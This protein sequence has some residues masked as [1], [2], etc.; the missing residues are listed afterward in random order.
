MEAARAIRLVAAFVVGIVLV[1]GCAM[2]YSVV[3]QMQQ[4]PPTATQKRPQIAQTSTTSAV[5]PSASPQVPVLNPSVVHV[6][7]LPNSP[8]SVAYVRVPD[9]TVVHAPVSEPHKTAISVPAPTLPETSNQPPNTAEFSQI[10][11]NQ[12]PTQPPPMVRTETGEPIAAPPPRSLQPHT[13]TLWSGTPVTVRLAEPLSTDQTKSGDYFHATLQSPLIQDGFVIADA[14]SGAVGQVIRSRRA[15]LFGH[16]PDLMLVLVQIRTTDNQI[17]HVLTT[18]WNDMGPSHNPVSGT[19]RS[20]VGAVSGALT[21]AA[22][23]SGLISEPN[24]E[25]GVSKDRNL[26]L[27]ANTVLQFRLAA[28]LSLTE[29]TH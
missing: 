19:F 16:A 24:S 25:P 7:V 2:I 29:H 1:M 27:P 4:H 20:A 12:L 18:S 10:A 22:R 5:V 15:G 28:P 23:G 3:P 6:P 8:P 9:V 14:G 17:V 21:G 13:V 26:I 11:S